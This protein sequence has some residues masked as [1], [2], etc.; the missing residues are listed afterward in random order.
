MSKVNLHDWMMAPAVILC[1]LAGS[2]SSGAGQRVSPGVFFVANEG[3]WDG[4]F[5]FRCDLGNAAY[6]VTTSGLTID[7]RE[8]N[9]P[10]YPPTKWGE[11][12][13]FPPFHGGKS[14]GELSSEAGVSVPPVEERDLDHRVIG[15]TRPESVVK[16]HV[17][18]LTFL[19]AN[20]HPEIIGEE[21][22]ASYSNYFLGRD[23][24]RWKGHV[25]N[26]AKVI[27]KDV[28]PGIDVEY[29]AQAEGVETVYRVKPGADPAMIAIQYEGLDA[30]LSVD[31]NGSLLLQTS[32]GIVKEQA[33][34]AYQIVNGRQV[35]VRVQYRVTGSEHVRAFVRGVRC[36]KG[37]G[38]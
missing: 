9:S 26:Y 5:S 4:D 31:A 12:S 13:D 1:V 22:L 20:P 33:P 23:S 24:C 35:E 27:A 25:G 38:D 37:N 8:H 14:K 21:K 34:F 7:L 15:Q 19:N 17:L 2:R 11:D 30:P 10:H 18:R 28:W 32:L 6:F 29:S 36:G 3:Q 16:G